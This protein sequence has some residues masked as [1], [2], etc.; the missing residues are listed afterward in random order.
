MLLRVTDD[1]GVTEID[2]ASIEVLPTA[3]LGDF[4]PDSDVDGADLVAYILSNDGIS[5]ADF[6]GNYGKVNSQ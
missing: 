2:F 1:E 5:L 4:E 6:A 3:C